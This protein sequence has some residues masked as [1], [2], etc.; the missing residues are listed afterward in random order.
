[1]SDD[2]QILFVWEG[3]LLRP[4]SQR[5]QR[6]CDAELVIGERYLV[7][8][9]H[10]ASEASRRHYFAML[11]DS[12]MNLPE[13]IAGMYPSPEHLRKRALIQ[14]GYCDTQ[15]LVCA[16]KAEAKRVAAFIRPTDEFGVV[17][18]REATVTRYTA[19]S[20]SMRA[21]GKQDFQASKQATLD[22]VSDLIGV[23]RKQLEENRPS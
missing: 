2:K 6:D 15:T 18:V 3:D 5:W 13:T 9:V 23:A 7:S 8:V 4:A 10:P 20:Q 1:M 17:T 14:T 16:S 22:W 19:K 12:W 11:K 21:M